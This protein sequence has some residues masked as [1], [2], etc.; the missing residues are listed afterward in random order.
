MIMKG[1]ICTGSY[2]NQYTFLEKHSESWNLSCSIQLLLKGRIFKTIML[3]NKKRNVFISC[4]IRLPS[5]LF[6]FRET[7]G[8][9]IFFILEKKKVPR[10]SKP[11]SSLSFF[12]ELLLTALVMTS[13]SL[14]WV[15]SKLNVW[16]YKTSS[17]LDVALQKIY[18]LLLM[19][20]YVRRSV[21]YVMNWFLP[22]KT[23]FRD[24][25]NSP[26]YCSDK[27]QYAFENVTV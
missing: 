9:L 14:Y 13:A 19:K 17:I 16:S 8:R 15:D 4:Q 21:V 18:K 20:L 24:V 3:N 5:S 22:F 1:N 26:I 7:L 11:S 27:R 25:H 12:L 2:E 23:C 6:L 10:N